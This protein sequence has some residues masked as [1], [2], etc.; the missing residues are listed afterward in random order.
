MEYFMLRLILN[1]ALH[2]LTLYLTQG[3]YV[4][5]HDMGE[6]G[7]FTVDIWTTVQLHLYVYTYLY[8]YCR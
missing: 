3:P 4:V 7:K 1:V 6:P 2:L 8:Q 5:E